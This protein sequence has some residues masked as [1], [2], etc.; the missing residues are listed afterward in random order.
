VPGPFL[1]RTITIFNLVFLPFTNL[2]TR[3]EKWCQQWCEWP[4]MARLE[5]IHVVSS[6]LK[7]VNVGAYLTPYMTKEEKIKLVILNAN[8][9]T[10]NNLLLRETQV[11]ILPDKI[12][13]GPCHFF[14]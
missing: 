9:D 14:W 3:A 5:T 10:K 8:F 7:P 12:K 11:L 4:S 1:L 6:V 13:E 2:L